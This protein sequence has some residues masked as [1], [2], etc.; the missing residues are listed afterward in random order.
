MEFRICL[1]LNLRDNGLFD[2]GFLDKSLLQFCCLGII[3]RENTSVL[4]NKF[5]SLEEVEASENLSPSF[6]TGR[7]RS[8]QIKIDELDDTVR[9][10]HAHTIRPSRN[11]NVPSGQP[12]VMY[13][14]PELYETKDF[15]APAGS[16]MC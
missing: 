4:R 10:W 16:S 14:L 6:T 15:L 7:L 9:V 1:F 12:N 13:S 11:S 2:G 8:V 5:L 3:Q